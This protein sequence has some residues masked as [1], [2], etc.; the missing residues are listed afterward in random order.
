MCYC[1]NDLRSGGVLKLGLDVKG[2]N[3]LYHDLVSGGVLIFRIKDT[4]PVE[5]M[6]RSVSDS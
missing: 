6:L 4:G 5:Y 1:L 3:Y 2:I